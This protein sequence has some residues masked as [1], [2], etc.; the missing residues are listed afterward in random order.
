MSLDFI[1]VSLSYISTKYVVL[2][3]NFLRRLIIASALGPSTFGEYAFIVIIME[4]MNY[5][6]LGIFHAMNKEVAINLDKQGKG[7]YIDRIINNTISFQSLN[8]LFIG[9]LLLIPYL[10]EVY[11]FINN[12][13]FD[14]KYLLYLIFL[15][16]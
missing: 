14:S 15:K 6:N 2:V 1:K 11:N 10:L 4:Y 8:S 13:F 3:L 9:V 5:S 12:P 7:N 16:I